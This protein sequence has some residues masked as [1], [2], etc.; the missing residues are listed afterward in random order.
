[1]KRQVTLRHTAR[2]DLLESFVF[3]SQDSPTAADRFLLSAED[4]FDQ[5]ADMPEIGHRWE[6]EDQRL[7]DVRVWHIKGFENWLIFY[8][9]AKDHIDILRV[10]HGA[11]DTSALLTAENE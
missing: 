6:S 10:L 4:S 3:I 7:Q 11:R 5:L 2:E 1:M 9:V 8:C